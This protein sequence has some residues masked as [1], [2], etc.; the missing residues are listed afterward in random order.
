MMVRVKHLSNMLLKW[1]T[2]KCPHD[3]IHLASCM[4]LG[5]P[6]TVC[7]I[8]LS[9]SLETIDLSAA[10][11]FYAPVLQEA[12]A[13]RQN[14]LGCPWV[15]TS[16][17]MKNFPG[18]NFFQKKQILVSLESRINFLNSFLSVLCSYWNQKKGSPSK[19]LITPKWQKHFTTWVEFLKSPHTSNTEGIFGL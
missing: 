13:C 3:L 12:I 8:I 1:E 16:S 19:V 5:F 17:W 9:L 4:P 11:C 2:C 7:G 10:M 18:G 6:D 15:F 14:I